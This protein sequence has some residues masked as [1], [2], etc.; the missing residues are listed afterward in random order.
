MNYRLFICVSGEDDLK[1]LY[2][3][4]IEKYKSRND[5]GFDLVIPSHITDNK[6]YSIRIDHEIQCMVLCDDKPCG[7]YLY[8]RSSIAK[9]L[10]RM[11][12]SVGII[13]AGYR[14]NIIAYVDHL[15]GEN[16]SFIRKYTK[17]FQLCSPTLTKF[18]DVI[19]VDELPKTIRGKGGFGSTD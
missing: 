14:G 17:L 2:V 7:Y 10:F 12:N 15:S 19:I 8:P 18:R 3:E 5:S 1:K 13:D 9:T 11:C 4:Q 16:G 6:A